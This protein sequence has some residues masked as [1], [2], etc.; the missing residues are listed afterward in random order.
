MGAQAV[1]ADGRRTPGTTFFGSSVPPGPNSG[2]TMIR[3]LAELY[4]PAIPHQ[5]DEHGISPSAC[6]AVRS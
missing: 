6:T 4:T 3:K 1:V 2:E 5:W